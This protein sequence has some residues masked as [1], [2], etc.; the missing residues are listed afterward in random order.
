MSFEDAARDIDMRAFA[1]WSDPE[2]IVANVFSLYKQWGAEFTPAQQRDLFGAMGR[3][4]KELAA[5]AQEA[6]GHAH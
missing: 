4:H 2:R 6:C 5:A 1:G 3:Y